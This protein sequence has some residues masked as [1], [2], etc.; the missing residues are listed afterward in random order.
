[1][2]VIEIGSRYS[3]LVTAKATRKNLE[4]NPDYIC[5]L[6]CKEPYP[7]EWLNSIAEVTKIIPS[8]VVTLPLETFS[9]LK[10]NDILFIDS[11]HVVS[12]FN[13]VFLN[14]LL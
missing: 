4:E 10:E 11:S 7:R 12:A 13:D 8:F 9:I 2:H 14:I 5:E 3:T 1:M 6:I